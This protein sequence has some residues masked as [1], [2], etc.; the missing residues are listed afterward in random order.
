MFLVS[1]D[2]KIESFELGLL[3]GQ[4]SHGFGWL[5]RDSGKLY[6][7]VIKSLATD[8]E[9]RQRC[10]ARTAPTLKKSDYANSAAISGLYWG[11]VIP[12]ADFEFCGTIPDFRSE[13]SG[14]NSDEQQS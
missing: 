6:T 9:L 13:T 12:L 4:C 2:N 11:A 14:R 1:T 8:I 3:F 7:R 10:H 5:N